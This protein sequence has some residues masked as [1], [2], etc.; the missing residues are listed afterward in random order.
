MHQINQMTQT[1]AMLITPFAVLNNKLVVL[2]FCAF[3]E[4]QNRT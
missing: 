1:V 2:V 4:I 3:T